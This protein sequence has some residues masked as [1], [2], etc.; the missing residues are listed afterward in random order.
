M[1]NQTSITL[2]DQAFKELETLARCYQTSRSRIICAAV[3][4]MA[5]QDRNAFFGGTHTIQNL[6]D[7]ANMHGVT[8]AP[9]DGPILGGSIDPDSP[10]LDLHEERLNE[11]IEA[12]NQPVTFKGQRGMTKSELKSLEGK[13]LPDAPAGTRFN[14]TGDGEKV[15]IEQDEVLPPVKDQE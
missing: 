14:Y 1:A 13:T 3:L 15:S 6:R 5:A 10:D 4:R 8:I 7:R 2:S 9:L 11:W 12:V